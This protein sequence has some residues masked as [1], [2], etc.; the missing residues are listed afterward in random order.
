MFITVILLSCQKYSKNVNLVAELT[1]VCEEIA[2]RTG[3]PYLIVSINK[4]Y[5]FRW[6]LRQAHIPPE[7]AKCP[8]GGTFGLEEPPGEPPRLDTDFEFIR[9]FINAVYFSGLFQTFDNL[10][11]FTL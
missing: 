11:V 6:D 1:V 2:V 9:C 3:I 8:T 5:Y 4:P 7:T 10:F